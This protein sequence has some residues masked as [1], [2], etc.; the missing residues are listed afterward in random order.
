MAYL[1]PT[2]AAKRGSSSGAGARRSCSFIAS[3]SSTL[4][5]S[6][7]GGAR[8]PVVDRLAEAV[9]RHAHHRYGLGAGGIERTQMRKQI[10]G[11]LDQI[12]ARRQ[13]ERGAGKLRRRPEG[14]QS[15]VIARRFG[16]EPQLGLRR[17]M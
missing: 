11:R 10:G 17:V 12:G 4:C 15:F 1:S 13:I 9:M 7:R 5:V 16:V 6:W 14:E 8:Q 2:M 3:P